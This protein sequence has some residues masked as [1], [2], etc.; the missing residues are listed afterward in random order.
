MKLFVMKNRRKKNKMQNFKIKETSYQ[1][2][3]GQ[4]KAVG[5]LLYYYQHGSDFSDICPLCKVTKEYHP[6]ALNCCEFCLWKIIEDEDCYS[7]SDREFNIRASYLTHQKKWH[8]VRIPMLRRWEKILKAE[9]ATRC[10]GG[11]E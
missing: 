1:E 3:I 5:S 7:F 9:M 10:D 4:S 8:K 2:L 11:E 6:R